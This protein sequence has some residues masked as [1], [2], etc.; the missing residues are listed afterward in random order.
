MP[1]ISSTEVVSSFCHDDE[2]R[3]WEDFGDLA[4]REWG[5][6]EALN[7]A[8]REE[9]LVDICAH[10]T[11]PGGSLLDVGCGNGW[12]GL[13]V[14][15]NGMRLVGLDTSP[16]QIAAARESALASG[17]DARFLLGTVA[18]LEPCDQFDS[19]LIHA[20]LHHVPA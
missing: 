6:T 12:L 10:L 19:I 20:V 16:S 2:A 9:L 13:K 14:A 8:V 18:D 17:Q 7:S 5:L 3:W 1:D 15:G 11:I 4:N